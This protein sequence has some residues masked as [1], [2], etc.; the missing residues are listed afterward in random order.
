MAESFTNPSS[1]VFHIGKDMVVNGV[2]IF[3]DIAQAVYHFKSKNYYK[4][5]QDCGMAIA[6]VF[7]GQENVR[8]PIQDTT[9]VLE[10]IAR[11]A[12]GII[13]GV[14]EQEVG[15]LV[16]CFQ[17]FKDIAIDVETAIKDFEENTL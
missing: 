14:L 16:R 8:S 6:A 7:L 11:F 17:D 5:G 3:E 10:D 2:Q 13:V 1:M 15:S 4:F 9:L 12:E